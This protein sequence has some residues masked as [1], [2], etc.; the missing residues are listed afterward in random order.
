M[1]TDPTAPVTANANLM[2]PAALEFLDKVIGLAGTMAPHTRHPR[3]LEAAGTSALG[4]LIDGLDVYYRRLRDLLDPGG[5]APSLAHK[6]REWLDA[7]LGGCPQ[8]TEQTQ[9]I[10]LIKDV[11]NLSV[12]NNGRVDDKFMSRWAH[13]GQF[14]I[15]EHL[16]VHLYTALAAPAILTTVTAYDSRVLAQSPDLGELISR[17][18]QRQFGALL[19][20]VEDMIGAT[21]DEWTT[22]A[23]SIEHFNTSGV[24]FDFAGVDTRFAQQGFG[25]RW[26][27]QETPLGLYAFSRRMM[28]AGPFT[29][30]AALTAW[31][32]GPR[33]PTA[34]ITQQSTDDHGWLTIETADGLS[35]Y[36][37]PDDFRDLFV[38]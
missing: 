36:L 16:P 28:I 11:R 8:S 33:I 1:T 27:E 3:F 37:H 18:R 12:H 19:E 31:L 38:L 32:S 30:E 29:D 6:N 21:R 14:T 9:F 34:Q 25:H 22:V 35:F 17:D 24:P 5:T 13:V 26:L 23:D 15:G 4:G 7:S 2:T 10:A 20:I